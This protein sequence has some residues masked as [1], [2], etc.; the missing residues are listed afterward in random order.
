[1]TD[2]SAAMGRLLPAD[3]FHAGV[4][5]AT[6]VLWLAAIVAAYV[7]LGL[8]A[9]QIFGPL[10]GLGV[11][12]LFLAAVVVAQPMAWLGERQL[13]ARRAVIRTEPSR[14]QTPGHGSALQGLGVHVY[15]G[16]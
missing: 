5:V 1:M 6:L 13:L 7:V 8:I 2:S 15:H 11:L 14:C 3:R 9:N 4:R 16:C 10:P 12:L